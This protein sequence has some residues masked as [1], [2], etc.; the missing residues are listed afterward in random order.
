MMKL[1]Y[2]LITP[3]QTI[4]YRARSDKSIL[5]LMDN[6]QNDHLQSVCKNFGDDF[7]SN[8]HKRNRA[9]ITDSLRAIFLRHQ[10][11]VGGVDAL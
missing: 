10:S 4:L 2:I 11:D 3:S 6:P 9:E 7:E 5:V 8:I 1:V